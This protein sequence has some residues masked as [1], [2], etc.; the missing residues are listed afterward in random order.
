[1]PKITELEDGGVDVDFAARPDAPLPTESVNVG[2]MMQDINEKTFLSHESDRVM[3]SGFE[4]LA[5]MGQICC[6][7]YDNDEASRSTWIANLEKQLRLFTSY[8]APKSDP[9]ENCSNVNLPFLS[10][11]ILQF[12]ARAY[13]ELIPSK[14]VVKGI[15]GGDEDIEKAE[16]GAAY[17]NYQLLY[18]MDEFEEG[19]DKSLIQLP[20]HGCIFRK[21]FFN[22]QEN[23]VESKYISAVDLVVNYGTENLAKAQN[24]TH[25]FYLS[26]NEVRERARSG[27]FLDFA[28]DLE[29]GAQ[30]ISSPI[31]ET[32]D[33]IIGVQ[34]TN[35]KRAPRK[36]IECHRG[37]D[38][39]GDG[40]HEPYVITV[41]YET[42]KVVRITSRKSVDALG[43]EV[44]LEYFTKYSFIPNPEGFYDLGFG[45]LL[46]GLNSAANTIV[47]HVIDAGTLANLQGGFVA[48][49]SGLKKGAI[50]M[51]MGEF[52]EVDAY[53]DDIR[54]AIY[55]FDFKGPNQTLYATLGLL[56]EYSKLVSSVSETMTGQLPASDTP[57]STVMALIEEGRKVY[58]AIQK[59]IYRG[60][61]RELD[62][63]RR[64]NSI[65]LDE[66][67]YFQVLGDSNI[68]QGE[69]VLIGRNDFAKRTDFIPV[70]DPTITSQA[71]KVLKAQ[72][73]YQDVMATQGDNQNVVFAARRRYYE[74]LEVPNIGEVMQPPPEPPDLSQEEENAGMIQGQPAT[75][76]PIQDHLGHLAVM[77]DFENG[78]FAEQLEAD[79]KKL[80]NQHRRSHIAELYLAEQGGQDGGVQQAGL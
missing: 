59:R 35:Y 8:M 4:C 68:P 14:K 42:K 74:A 80:L 67:K 33:K 72:Q 73:V 1:M 31:R 53:V 55:T 2:L 18:E 25:I 26:K 7:D 27:V 77:D 16:R 12:Q 44:T 9:W 22:A 65:F 47:N 39:D 19:M 71:E 52:P 3:L 6:E 36:F 21:T 49:R 66:V 24:I 79:T 64:L 46:M 61:K 10:I 5:E 70:A 75:V 30:P 38:L 41:D 60:F 57:A 78:P 13:N 56:Y 37:W 29:E 40:L 23:K 62:K 63:I 51:K 50:S 20:L 32:T 48:K 11:A 28:F 17:M 15:P 69:Q 34:P 45:T 76:L 58:S 54:K 43:K